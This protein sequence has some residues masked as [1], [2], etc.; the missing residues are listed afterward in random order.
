MA[1]QFAAKAAVVA[2]APQRK[3]VVARGAHAA[4]CVGH[5]K[6]LPPAVGGQHFEGRLSP[7]P[8]RAPTMI[9][10][11]SKG[12]LDA[13]TKL[14]NPQSPSQQQPRFPLR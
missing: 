7:N 2:A 8:P 3:G 12:Q 11:Y 10:L 1:K 5:P 14:R 9:V 13:V 6:R 4:R